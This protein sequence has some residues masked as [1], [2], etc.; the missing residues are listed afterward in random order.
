MP[1]VSD[2][3]FLLAV[4]NIFVKKNIQPQ[5][6][7]RTRHENFIHSVRII[8]YEAA[9]TYVVLKMKFYT[10]MTRAGRENYIH[11]ALCFYGNFYFF[12]RGEV[13]PGKKT[14]ELKS[15]LLHELAAN[16]RAIVRTDSRGRHR[17]DRSVSQSVCPT[18]SF[19]HRDSRKLRLRS[20]SLPEALYG[21]NAIYRQQSVYA[22]GKKGTRA[23][24]TYART[25][26]QDDAAL[27]EFLDP[28]HSAWLFITCTI[29][30]GVILPSRCRKSKNG[31]RKRRR[32]SIR[33]AQRPSFNFANLLVDIRK[34]FDIES[35]TFSIRSGSYIVAFIFERCFQ[36]LNERDKMQ[37]MKFQMIKWNRCR[38]F[39][40]N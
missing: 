25:L 26:P 16:R 22:G 10:R 20:F 21:G 9:C 19:W 3:L 17:I 33:F 1:F 4:S 32:F 38:N 12:S 28:R 23:W 27:I 13:H 29:Y 35:E 11:S 24:Y 6:A 36:S 5:F 15:R 30:L 39:Y 31:D 14:G 34:S 37:I 7:Q 40:D 18:M 8:P 2:C